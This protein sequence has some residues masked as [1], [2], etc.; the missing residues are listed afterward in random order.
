MQTIRELNPDAVIFMQKYYN[1]WSGFAYIAYNAGLSRVNAAID[2]YNEEH[3]GEV[4][5]CDFSSVMNGHKEYLADDC[6]H[7]NSKGNVAIARYVLKQFHDMGLCEATEPVINVPGEDY[8]YFEVYINKTFGSLI[9]V[10][11]KIM[12]GNAV[13]LFR[14]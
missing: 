5:L 10:I 9:T 13:N 11:V 12:T 1:S 14:K 6:V 4:T 2:R 7:P 3:P 8:N